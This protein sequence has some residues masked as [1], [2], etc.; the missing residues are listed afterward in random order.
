MGLS[1][2]RGKQV[3][4]QRA[5]IYGPEGIGKSTL[6]SYFP[7]PVFLD[8]EEGTEQMDVARLPRPLSWRATLGA[9]QALQREPSGFGTLVID[10]GDAAERLAI[11]AVCGEHGLSGLGG[12][13][14]YGH[15]YGLLAKEWGQFLD[16][17][18]ELRKAMNVVI[19][20]HAHQR[21]VEIPEET[22]AYDHWELKLEKKTSALTLE[23]ADMVL[24]ARYKT[25]VVKDEKT[26]SNKAT[27]GQRVIATQ[28]HPCW[29]A[30]N[31][32]SLP[33]ELPFP[34]GSDA[35]L[36][37]APCFPGPALSEAAPPPPQAP[38]PAPPTPAPTPTPAVPT[39]TPTPALPA[40]M[41]E[42]LR[43]LMAD[44]GI[45]AGELM[46]Q[47][48]KRGH[49]P[50]GTPIENLPADYVEGALLPHWAKI[51]DLILKQRGGAA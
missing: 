34:N 8:I 41:N 26:K 28:H 49:F 2:T 16:A 36:L 18:T 33:A 27:G 32:H 45:G 9:V 23:W 3:T 17:L 21:R 39:P 6:A 50:S 35:F 43:Q 24:F 11:A 48:Y 30:K 51:S 10:T 44:K 7:N 38:K 1:V 46:E 5:V 29:S 25:M 47:V 19:V 22:G 31:R 13:N 12:N 20:C 40:G 4:F 42:Q 37:L 14:D 15:S